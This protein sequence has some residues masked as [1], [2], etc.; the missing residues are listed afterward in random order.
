MVAKKRKLTGIVGEGRDFSGPC[1]PL[2][3]DAF[4]K[5]SLDFHYIVG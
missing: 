4:N 3:S 2:G 1:V 5:I